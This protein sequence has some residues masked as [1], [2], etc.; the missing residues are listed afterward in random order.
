M[1]QRYGV[2]AFFG[3]ASQAEG[4]MDI[5]DYA[6]GLVE[7]LAPDARSSGPAGGRRRRA[8]ERNREF[9]LY[10][11]FAEAFSTR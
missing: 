8:G 9:G 11:E 6:A 3:D 2:F 10:D 7:E 5:E 4:R 1:A